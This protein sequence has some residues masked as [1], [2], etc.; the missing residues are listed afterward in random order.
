VADV[1]FDGRKVLFAM[2]SWA[3][4]MPGEYQG[5][6]GCHEAKTEAPPRTIAVA[7]SK[8]QRLH[9]APGQGAHPLLARLE[10]GGRLANVANYLGVNAARSFAPDAPTEG[11]SYPRLVQPVLDRNCVRCHDG[12]EAKR[13]NLTGHLTDSYS[14]IHDGRPVDPGRRYSESTTW[15]AAERE[16][17]GY[18]QTKRV[19]FAEQ[20]RRAIIDSDPDSDGS[21]CP[22]C[23]P[24]SGSVSRSRFRGREP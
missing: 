3:T 11:F 24:S 8:V 12:T 23:P 4:L 6:V 19:A 18:Y 13:P 22:Q 15:T 21:A 9:P 1:S 2:R 20:E 7:R 17:Y 14:P 5:C 16:K 10:R